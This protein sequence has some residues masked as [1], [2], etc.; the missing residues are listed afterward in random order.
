M[1]MVALVASALLLL[2]SLY[3]FKYHLRPRRLMGWY[4]E[5]LEAMGYNV[6]AFP[7]APHKIMLL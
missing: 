1:L 6:I 5:T 2:L 4:R 7:Y 3:Y